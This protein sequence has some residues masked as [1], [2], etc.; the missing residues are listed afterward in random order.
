MSQPEQL[1][2]FERFHHKCEHLWL[3]VPLHDEYRTEL[4]RLALRDS[5]QPR[6]TFKIHGELRQLMRLK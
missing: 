4:I 6:G 5:K 3:E 1:T 2:P